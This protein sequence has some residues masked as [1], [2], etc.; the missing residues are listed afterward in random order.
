MES[1][2]AFSC[3][4]WCYVVV[5]AIVFFLSQDQC[6]V[7]VHT[8]YTTLFVIYTVFIFTKSNEILLTN[9]D[10]H[11]HIIVHRPN[12]KS[13]DLFSL[14][15]D[16]CLCL[17]FSPVCH[18]I[19]WST[20]HT[21]LFAQKTGV[22]QNCVNL[23]NFKCCFSTWKLKFIFALRCQFINTKNTEDMCFDRVRSRKKWQ[24]VTV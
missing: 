19:F 1:F 14:F 22:S 9:L 17:Y 7:H 8:Q 18:E 12:K 6:R 16:I 2:L 23:W 11:A 5:V 3:C 24:A 10:W 21:Q 15:S 4:Y 13:T 20:I